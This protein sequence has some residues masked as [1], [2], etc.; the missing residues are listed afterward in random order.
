MSYSLTLGAGKWRD[1]VLNLVAK[2]IKIRYMGAALG[3]AWS[4]GNPLVVTLTY[5]A[6][7][8]YILPSNQDRFA[9]HLVTGVVHWMLFSQILLQSSEWLINNNSLIKKLRFPRILL[10]L[11]GA[12]TAGSFWLVAMAVYACLY[13]FIGGY[14]T[15][16]LAWYPA[17]LI[18]FIALIAGLG[19]A[20]SVLQVTHR[21]VK[22]VTEVFVPLLFW[23]TPIVWMT[24]SLP[25][26]VASIVAYNPVAPF[27]NGFTMILHDGVRP[28]WEQLALCWGIGIGVLIAGLLVF[29]RA[30]SVV[31]HL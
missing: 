6:V 27:F 10:P 3:F 31:E 26:E 22:H 2:E 14:L 25:P 15:P 1:L 12:L 7:F 23:F 9:L 30:D 24:S 5:Y 18:P 17:V 19:L 20:A 16:A 29:K 13:T 21:D 28:S 8:T 4:L 11:S